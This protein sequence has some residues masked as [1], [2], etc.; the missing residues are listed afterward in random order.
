MINSGLVP[1]DLE[2][3]GLGTR[4]RRFYETHVFKNKFTYYL[5][6]AQIWTDL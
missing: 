3:T 1:A 5:R 4:A 2:T 6:V